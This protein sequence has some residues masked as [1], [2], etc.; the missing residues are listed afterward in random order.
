MLK[1]QFAMVVSQMHR[2]GMRFEEAVC[3]FQ[4]TFILTVLRDCRGN[5]CSAAKKLRMH[6]NT[7][8]RTIRTLKL[9]LLSVR[10]PSNRRVPH[11]EL[12]VGIPAIR[13]RA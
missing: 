1:G 11:G 2:R 4:S 5:Q 13:A 3:E 10:R 9:D 8:R 7:L 6:R 12:V